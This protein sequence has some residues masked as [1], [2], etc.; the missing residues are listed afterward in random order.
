VGPSSFV[1]SQIIQTGSN[2]K[3][4]MDVLPCSKNSQSLH[5]DALEHCEQFSKLCRHLNL[6]TIRVK[7]LGTD[8]PFES[9]MNLK[10]GLI[11]LEK[12]D[13][14]PKNPS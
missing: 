5:A 12:S 1:F 7:N 6:H 13:K 9:L 4:K 3:L 8:S 10:K 2:W 14:L 11:L